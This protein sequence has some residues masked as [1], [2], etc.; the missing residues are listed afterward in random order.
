MTLK[1]AC[2]P[3]LV[4]MTP[5]HPV[6]FQSH[7]SQLSSCVFLSL[8]KTR[9]GY[10]NR[11][12][13]YFLDGCH[14][15]M[16]FLLATAD[17]HLLSATANPNAATDTQQ[18]RLWSGESFLIH[19]TYG[20]FL[21]SHCLSHRPPIV[22]LT[23]RQRT[24]CPETSLLGTSCLELMFLSVMALRGHYYKYMTTPGQPLNETGDCP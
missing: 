22:F 15:V 9:D 2:F 8:S 7:P 23:C 17:E 19:P 18:L 1:Q 5:P 13:M 10:H 12:L 20:F 3:C 16:P 4:Y 21:I 6:T 24:P 14:N 11:L